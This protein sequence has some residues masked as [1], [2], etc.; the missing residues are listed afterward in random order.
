MGTAATP[1]DCLRC[2]EAAAELRRRLHALGF[3]TVGFAAVADAVPGGAALR[4]W[5]AGGLHAEMAWMERTAE[6]RLDPRQV[7]PGV[8]SMVLLGVN[9]APAATASRSPGW[10]R[11]AGYEDYHETL[12]PALAQAGH[13]LEELY[14]L[15]P[16]DYR[17]YV[18]AG[19]VLERAWTVQAGGGFIG[20]N[21]MLIAPAWGNWLLLA[22][23]LTRAELPPEEPRPGHR[24]GVG[25]HC[26]KC[27]RCLTACPTGALIRPG[28]VDA[29]RCVSYLT[30][31]HKGA[32]PREW[33]AALGDHLYGCDVCAEV[34]PWNR[35]ARAGRSPL[36]VSRPE[37]AQLPLREIL[38]LTPERFAAVFR[39]TPVKRLK[40]PG[41]LRNACVV[42]GNSGDLRL[43]DPLVQLAAQAAPLVRAH[44]V[45]AVRRLVGGPRSDTL[46][47]AARAGE[48]EASVLAEYAAAEGED[49]RGSHGAD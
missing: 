9:Y 3:D 34:C 7:L 27:T 11:Y 32:I 39:R 35:F 29:R 12:R 33:R 38:E 48:T 36:L 43:L 16:A 37:L 19:P 5:L 42:A 2:G 4:A 10:A 31:E 15:G 1:T 41:L 22:A 28:V 8:R 45:W 44:A 21:A 20:K 26:G 40:L 25:A 30:I 13:V 46:L 47:A 6:K 23:I 24:A 49:G 18:D 17:Y 14:G